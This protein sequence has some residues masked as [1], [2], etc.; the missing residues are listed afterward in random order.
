MNHL[1]QVTHTFLVYLQH[2]MIISITYAPG[3]TASKCIVKLTKAWKVL[4]SE[5]IISEKL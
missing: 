2:C 1:T 4:A 3:V 5:I